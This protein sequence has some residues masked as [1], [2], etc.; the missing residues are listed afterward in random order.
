MS[1]IQRVLATLQRKVMYDENYDTPVNC[2]FVGTIEVWKS[3]EEY[4]SHIGAFGRQLESLK[5][6]V[7]A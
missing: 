4:D 2:Y 1:K 5:Q 6:A 7:G 3:L